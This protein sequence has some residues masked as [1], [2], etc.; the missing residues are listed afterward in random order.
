MSVDWIDRIAKG[1]GMMR[2]LR[3]SSFGML[4]GWC[5]V[6]VLALLLASACDSVVEP[7]PVDDYELLFVNSEDGKPGQDIYRMNSDGTGRQ[8]LTNLST[9]QYP[10]FVLSVEYRSLALSPDGRKIAFESLREG[11]PGIW[12]MNVDG[13]DIRKLS[14]GEYQAT[15]CN[16]FP[17]WSRDGSRIA[18]VTSREGKWSMYVMNADG[19]NP[20]NVAPSL[21]DAGGFFSPATWS[22]DGRLAFEVR[23]N[24]ATPQAYVVNSDGTNPGFL[25]GRTGDHSPSWSPD[26]SKVA[27]IRNTGTGSSLFVMNADG[28]NVRRL[29]DHPGQDVF[30]WGFFPNDYDRWSP[31]GRRIVFSNVIDNRAELR[32][33]DADG[34]NNVRLTTYNAEFN[35][36][37]PDGRVTFSSNVN[38]SQDLFLI[39]RDGTGRV[40]LTNTPASHE[41]R[42]LWVRRQ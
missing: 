30:W 11:C 34:T 29:T 31:D 35:G 3:S 21:D 41:I 13:S 20:R 42:G 38:G 17:T 36:W 4:S 9:V 28:S 26:G 40:N 8:N 37:A 12:G 39:N 32:V 23:S 10:T 2:G 24:Q 14:I 15:R 5:R 7:D 16:H 1:P 18:F 27:F 22:P 33:V 6:A 25:F 19:T